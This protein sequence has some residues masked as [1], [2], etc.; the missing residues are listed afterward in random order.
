MYGTHA[1]VHAAQ[2]HQRKN[3]EEE[4]KMTK[5]TNEDLDHGWEF[6]IVRSSSGAFRKPEVMQAVMDEEAQ[7]GWEMIEKFDNHRIRF[8]RPSSARRNDL[9]LPVYLDPYRTQYGGNLANYGVV[10]GVGIMVA[11]L[12]AG[13]AIFLFLAS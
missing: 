3:E 10:I 9:S 13:V 11:L 7:A 5:Y 4:E 6:K 2:E 8:K 1:A 12:L